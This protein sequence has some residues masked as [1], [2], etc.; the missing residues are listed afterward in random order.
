MVG[1]PG[2]P[3]LA[4]PGARRRRFLALMVVAPRPSAPTPPGGP[5][6][7]AQKNV[8]DN[9]AGR[10]RVG[11]TCG[12]IDSP[13]VGLGASIDTLKTEY[14]RIQALSQDKE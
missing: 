9:R 14:P 5:P 13:E 1:A 3:A 4:P 8:L 7:T 12:F 11:P 10:R 2:P 6:S